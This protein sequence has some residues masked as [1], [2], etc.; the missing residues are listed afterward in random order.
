MKYRICAD[1]ALSKRPAVAGGRRDLSTLFG[2]SPA[3]RIDV[4]LKPRGAARSELSAVRA[5]WGSGYG[6]CSSRG[7]RSLVGLD[8]E[9]HTTSV[10]VWIVSGVEHRLELV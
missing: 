4:L 9:T 5:Y 3:T 6:N 7:G 8:R 1:L 10:V 2:R